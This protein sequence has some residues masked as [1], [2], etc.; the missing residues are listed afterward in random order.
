[1]LPRPRRH[2]G[3]DAVLRAPAPGKAGDQLRRELHRVQ[4][5]PP[6]FFGVIGQAAGPTA[7][8]AHHAGTD[9]RKADLDSSSLELEVDRLHTPGVIEA[10]KTGV[11]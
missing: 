11:A 7:L 9:V 4:V 1:M 2:D 3:F 8:G 6:P 5:P 10:Q